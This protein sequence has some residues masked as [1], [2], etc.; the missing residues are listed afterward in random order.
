MQ[1]LRLNE[2][3]KLDTHT[4]E[5]PRKAHYDAVALVHDELWQLRAAI[6]AQHY[7]IAYAEV[8]SSVIAAFTVRFAHRAPSRGKDS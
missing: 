1:R 7:F 3:R 2:I 6:H 8:F 4:V 5:A